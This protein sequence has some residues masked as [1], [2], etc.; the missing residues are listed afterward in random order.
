MS[1]NIPV[2][3][4]P[5]WLNKEFF[6]DLLQKGNERNISVEIKE[7]QNAVP[8]GDNYLSIIH[9]ITLSI[10]EEGG[11]TT[12]RSL[13]VK[14]LPKGE[15]LQK[16]LKEGGI[17]KQEISMY[18]KVLP[19]F[20]RI[21]EGRLEAPSLTAKCYPLDNDE[22]LV[23][24][25]LR[26]SGFRMAD[27]RQGL[28]YDHC[29][30]AVK[31]L[32]RLHGMSVATHEQDPDVFQ[33]L[34]IEK[35]YT[36]SGRDNVKFHL[37]R[38]FKK[39]KEVVEGMNG[40]ERF[41]EKIQRIHDDLM[42]NMIM[43]MNPEKNVFRV[44]NH[45]DFWVNNML[46]SYDEKDK[47]SDIKMLDFQMS[48]FVTPALDLHYFLVS[49]PSM[50]VRKNSVDH[51]LEEYH[52]ELCDVLKRLDCAHK[53]ITLQRLQEELKDN[54]FFA[55][56]VMAALLAIVVA[57]PE[58]APDFSDMTEES[59]KSGEDNTMSKSYAGARYRE[60]VQM[61]LLRFEEQGIL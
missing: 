25:D 56:N 3:E 32:A 20:Y 27:R 57:D 4:P 2:T 53:Q 54:G 10:S 59:I 60:L 35:I 48:K 34:K 19:A 43:M 6:E 29:L 37:D 8:V 61:L 21:A 49:S 36:E 24:E 50:E 42:D 46:F 12:E 1:E 16:F 39:L 38:P 30:V 23:M 13:I 52:T 51:L 15:M 22:L 28:D 33:D 31:A 45:G 26:P 44:M 58:D 18:Q 14:D 47:V 11:R 7:V 17:F 41:V 5:S 55:V 9:R 40:F